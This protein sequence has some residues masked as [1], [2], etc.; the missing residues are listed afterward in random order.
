MRPPEDYFERDEDGIRLKGHRMWLEDILELY[1][2]G[3][4]P[5]RI[6]DEE[7]YP[8]LALDEVEAAIAY[9]VAH[10]AEVEAYLEQQRAEAE[11]RER[12]A[13]EHPSPTA[14]R[15]RAILEKRRRSR[16]QQV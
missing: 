14:L 7:H 12:L 11:A 9:Y 3:L 5:E 2:S 1:A 10:Q 8:T 13:D 4:A 15:L 6:V 16:T